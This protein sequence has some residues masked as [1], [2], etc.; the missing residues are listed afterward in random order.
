[1][2][3]LR[4][5]TEKKGLLNINTIMD[6]RELE[7]TQQES[8]SQE[9]TLSES[10]LV[11]RDEEVLLKAGGITITEKMYGKIFDEKRGKHETRAIG[12][13]NLIS[14]RLQEA[15]DLK[16]FSYIWTAA[17]FLALGFCLVHPAW[18]LSVDA[19][20]DWMLYENERF[21][22]EVEYPYVLSNVVNEPDNGDG[23][24]LASEDGSCRLTI[25][26]GYNVLEEDAETKLEGRLK[27][28]SHIR[29]L[30]D[31]FG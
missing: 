10:E 17:V 8:I 19:A 23:V 25:S 7:R 12:G 3:G 1:M 18:V 9:M 24:E 16:R 6:R 28:V 14:G 4:A 11:K 31:T 29:R 13:G 22:Y 15:I 26:G 30:R 5:I 20:E 27:E 2:P 21:G